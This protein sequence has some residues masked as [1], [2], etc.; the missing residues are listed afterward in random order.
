MGASGSTAATTKLWLGVRKLSRTAKIGGP[1]VAIHAYE[2]HECE[3]GRLTALRTYHF[4]AIEYQRELE[5]EDLRLEG[6][7]LQRV[8]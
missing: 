2:D 1:T 8:R 4:V 5:L 7:R 6:K 3:H